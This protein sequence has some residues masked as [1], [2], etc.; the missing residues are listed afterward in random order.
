MTMSMT[1]HL[2]WLWGWFLFGQSLYVLK[3]AYY[4]VTGP[5]KVATTYGEFFTSPKIW[6]VLVI[7]A[8]AG[9]VVYWAFFYPEIISGFLDKLGF[10]YQFHSPIPQYGFVAWCFGFTVDAILDILVTKIPYIKDL[11]PQIPPPLAEPEKKEDK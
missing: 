9:G 4:L 2:V 3:R 6:P 8:T 7:R 1:L 10:S 5:N 11:L